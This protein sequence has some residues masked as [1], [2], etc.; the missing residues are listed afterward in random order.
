MCQSTHFLRFIQSCSPQSRDA[1]CRSWGFTLADGSLEHTVHSSPSP[2]SL[3]Q[4]GEKS[5]VGMWYPREGPTEHQ[6][7][8]LKHLALLT[9]RETPQ[10]LLTVG[11]GRPLPDVFTKTLRFWMKRW[12]V[13]WLVCREHPSWMWW[14]LTLERL[15]ALR[16]FV[17]GQQEEHRCMKRGAAKYK[18][19]PCRAPPRETSRRHQGTSGSERS[20]QCSLC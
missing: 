2:S 7:C 6:M 18:S 3:Q 1:D 4:A 15:R 14:L 8:V 16:K 20:G 12:V 9:W 13:T 19:S 17:L 5:F 10:P 11:G